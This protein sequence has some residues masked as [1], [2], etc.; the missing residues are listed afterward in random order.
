[1]ETKPGGVADAAH[2]SRDRAGG[3]AAR[4]RSGWSASFV[5]LIGAVLLVAA[6]TS[7]PPPEE[8]ESVSPSDSATSAYF[9]RLA[10]NADPR[11]VAADY[12]V[13]PDSVIVTERTRAFRGTLTSAQ[14]ERLRQDERV[15]SVSI[16]IE[17]AGWRPRDPVPLPDSSSDDSLRTW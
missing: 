13:V 5:P 11:A 2:G 8:G 4:R 7:A 10:P 12:D 1:M 15:R 9:V 6:C 17:G 16:R 3:R 14:A